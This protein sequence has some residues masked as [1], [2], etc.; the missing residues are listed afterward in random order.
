MGTSTR[1]RRDEGKISM[2]PLFPKEPQ[3]L[4]K[5]NSSLLCKNLPREQDHRHNLYLNALS[6][7]G[8]IP[9]NVYDTGL[10][11]LP[12]RS[13][14]INSRASGIAPG[15]GFVDSSNLRKSSGM[16]SWHDDHFRNIVNLN[17][18]NVTQKFNL[19]KKDMQ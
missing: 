9:K 13:N 17:N 1:K 7:A 5:L 18:S 6:R 10:T 16:K 8:L 15:G 4:P 2:G 11:W 19:S 3:R 12:E 14:L